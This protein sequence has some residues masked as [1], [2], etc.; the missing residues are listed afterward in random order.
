MARSGYC[1]DSD[2]LIWQLRNVKRREKITDHLAQL[3]RS[4]ALSCSA[5]S[6]AEVAQGLRAGEEAKTQVLFDAL[7]V[8]PVDRVIADRAGAIV[9]VLKSRVRTL[10]LADAIIAATCLIHDLVLVTLNVRDFEQVE[11]LAIETAP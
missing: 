11:G 3:A 2:V 4:G 1:L 6:V 10:G 7:D 9:R 8:H 5:L